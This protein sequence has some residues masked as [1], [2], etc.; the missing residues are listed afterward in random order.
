MLLLAGIC[1]AST[2]AIRR[3]IDYRF[4]E[5]IDHPHQLTEFFAGA[6][7]EECSG[8]ECPILNP[9]ELVTPQATEFF[10]R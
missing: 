7:P 8:S 4:R 5:R 1:N 2:T 10:R 9:D 3:P 6:D